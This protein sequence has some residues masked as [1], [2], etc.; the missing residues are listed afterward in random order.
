MPSVA[1]RGGTL[2]SGFGNRLMRAFALFTMAEVTFFPLFSSVLEY[3]RVV[4]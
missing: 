3:S 4:G 2:N 1:R